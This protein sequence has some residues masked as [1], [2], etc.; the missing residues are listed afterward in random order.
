M[1]NNGVLV[2]AICLHC[3]AKCRTVSVEVLLVLTPP[4]PPTAAGGLREAGGLGK[5]KTCIYI[6]IY[7][8]MNFLTRFFS[9]KVL[10]NEVTKFYDRTN[11]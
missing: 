7:S 5:C 3:R 4:P 11:L 2:S 1:S 6:Y 9:K 8:S 10:H